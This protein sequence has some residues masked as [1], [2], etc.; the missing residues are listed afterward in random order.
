MEDNLGRGVRNNDQTFARFFLL[1][2][3]GEYQFLRSQ[4]GIPSIQLLPPPLHILYERSLSAEVMKGE[5]LVM[6]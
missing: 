6:P 5:H 2:G 1:G 3:L 4:F